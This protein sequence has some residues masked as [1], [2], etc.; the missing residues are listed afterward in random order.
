[1]IKSCL[2]RILFVLAISCFFAACN[3]NTPQGVNAQTS[4]VGFILA[5]SMNATVFESAVQRSHLDTVFNQPGPFTVFVPNNDACSNSGISQITM[6]GYSDSMARNL[7]LYHTVAGT[8]LTIASLH[9][10][11]VL[12]II[13]AN[14]DSAYITSDTTHLYI[15][16]IPAQASDII[17]SNGV[18]D[19]IQAVLTPPGGNLLQM[20]Q[21]DTALSLLSAAIQ[22]AS[23]GTVPID[24]LLNN[25][26]PYTLFAPINDAFRQAN[27]FSPDDINYANPDSLAWLLMNHMIPSR[28]FA[29]DMPVGSSRMNLNDSTISFLSNGIN[30]QV[31]V[32]GSDT[33][34]NVL[35]ANG[36]ARNGVFYKVDLLLK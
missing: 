33:L 16:G 36:M 23:Q 28:L 14:G 13:M 5:N 10:A 9:F 8:A 17:A 26:G 31:Q 19:A 25:S 1:M 12:K 20:V 24:S 11:S 34:S 32:S 29:C 7:V 27:Y 2:Y 6:D 22:R 4:T 21:S 18:L 15:N 35:F 30:S 3:K